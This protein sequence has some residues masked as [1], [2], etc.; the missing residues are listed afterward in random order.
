MSVCSLLRAR[1]GALLEHWLKRVY[2]AYP[3]DTAGFS[4]TGAN[5]FAN[6]IEHATRTSAETIMAAVRGQDI[7]E[8]AL[9]GALEDMIRIRA[10]QPF[11]PEQ[12]AG[13]LFLLKSSIRELLREKLDSVTLYAELLD[14]EARI[15][16]LA[17][18]A[19]GMHSA[20]RERLYAQRVE[21]FKRSHA[22]LF[23]LA[24][25][26]SAVP[27]K[28]ENRRRAEHAKADA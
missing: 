4:H 27:R 3:L 24:E 25:R 1:E 12:A 19:F 15:D 21:E 7:P 20:L 23:R 10:V 17:L 18:M 5:Q 14:V 16:S 13:V 22:S 11:S 6:P 28:T 26:R 9:K 2:A 8:A